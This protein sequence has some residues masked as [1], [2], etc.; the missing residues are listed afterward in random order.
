MTSTEDFAKQAEPELRSSRKLSA[1]TC[2]T[3][4]NLDDEGQ[5]A[6]VQAM[7]FICDDPNPIHS[8]IDRN[9]LTRRVDR[10]AASRLMLL[11]FKVDTPE[12]AWSSH[13]LARY[14]R[15]VISVPGAS[16]DDVFNPLFS[17]LGELGPELTPS[18]AHLVKDIVV[19]C[20]SACREEYESVNWRAIAQAMGPQSTRA[21][22]SSTSRHTS[23]IYDARRGGNN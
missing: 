1:A 15:A 20:F 4:R 22:L 12:P 6:F 3:L 10:L 8:G 5:A 17:L 23:R 2:R 18:V 19:Y 21:V 13:A 7:E 16:L 11:K 9:L 14:V